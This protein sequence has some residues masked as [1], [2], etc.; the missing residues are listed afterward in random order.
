MIDDT[1]KI[2]IRTATADLATSLIQG[3]HYAGLHLARLLVAD[4]SKACRLF[5]R[6]VP[7]RLQRWPT[8]VNYHRLSASDL[9]GD[10][11]SPEVPG[12]S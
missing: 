12:H 6:A 11:Q 5:A 1:R 8:K 7:E 10:F 2:E 4:E 3:N 9:G